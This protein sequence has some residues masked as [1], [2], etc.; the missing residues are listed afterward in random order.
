MYVGLQDCMSSL[1]HPYVWLS[2][3][4]TAIYLSK[5]RDGNGS[6]GRWAGKYGVGQHLVDYLLRGSHTSAQVHKGRRE[7]G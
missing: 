7:T 5:Q 6:A 4:A 1:K 3:G 2:Y